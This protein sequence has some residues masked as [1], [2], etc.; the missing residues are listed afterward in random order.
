MKASIQDLLKGLKDRNLTVR[1]DA[2]V[3]LAIMR[4]EV[5]PPLLELLREGKAFFYDSDDC[6]ATEIAY[7]VGQ[8]L[9]PQIAIPALIELLKTTTND[10][11][12]KETACA[13]RMVGPLAKDAVFALNEALTNKNPNTRRD[14]ALALGAIGQPDKGAI[15][16]LAGILQDEK[17]D[18]QVRAAATR[19]LGMLGPSAS[20]AIRALATR[21]LNDFCQSGSEIV[22][23][24]AI[25]AHAVMQQNPTAA[26]SILLASLHESGDAEIRQQSA[27]AIKML[28]NNVLAAP[29]LAKA[30]SELTQALEDPHPIVRSEIALGLAALGAAATK[31]DKA[32]A[33]VLSNDPDVHVRSAAAEALR[34]IAPSADVVLE[35][36]TGALDVDH[37]KDAQVREL[38]VLALHR[39][40]EQARPAIGKLLLCLED[41]NP[42]VC[43][44]AA[45]A[46]R[47]IAPYQEA[48]VKGLAQ[49]LSSEFPEVRLIVATV[50]GDFASSA[51]LAAPGLVA[52]LNDGDQWVRDEASH[53]LSAVGEAAV[54]RLLDVMAKATSDADRQR[55]ARVIKDIDEEAIPGLLKRLEDKDVN[56]GQAVVEL[57]KSMSKHA[58]T[59]RS[60]LF[61][62]LDD[63]APDK[64]HAKLRVLSILGGL[65]FD[66]ATS[67]SKLI[68]LLGN[69][70]LAEF[71][72][73][74]LLASSLH[75]IRPLIEALAAHNPILVGSAAGT[76]REIT[77]RVRPD[78][79][80]L[81]A[82]LKDAIPRLKELLVINARDPAP[83]REIK[84]MEAVSRNV[85]G[86]LK[87]LAR[88][89]P[90]A[91]DALAPGIGRLINALSDPADLSTVGDAAQALTENTKRADATNE[92]FVAALR[93]IVPRLKKLL[94]IY[95][96]DPIAGQAATQS[97]IRNVGGALKELAFF[98]PDAAL[99]RKTFD[100]NHE[101]TDTDIGN[102]DE[103]GDRGDCLQLS[104]LEEKLDKARVTFDSVV[105][106]LAEERRRQARRLQN[107]LNKYLLLW[108]KHQQQLDEIGD[109]RPAKEVFQAKHELA[110]RVSKR[111]GSVHFAIRYKDQ[112]NDLMSNSSKGNR[113]GWFLLRPKGISTPSVTKA[114]L[115]DLLNITSPPGGTP[116][117]ELVEAPA[118]RESL[119]EWRERIRT[120]FA[121][122]R[123][124]SLDR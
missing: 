29:Q 106:M 93:P 6:P 102:R 18:A 10:L 74:L 1:R 118:R 30:L 24:Q 96:R 119:V 73:S 45:L 35:A 28:A 97:A 80:E 37:E 34:F 68:R 122:T 39:L 105:E 49:A 56:V 120:G 90:D 75:V 11:V 77:R 100:S 110:E 50:L 91:A 59:L 41:S 111:L 85:R 115:A 107:A 55:A 23:I 4:Q 117:F 88:F 15:Q 84:E 62:I 98:Y 52:L 108:A 32:L 78:E 12:V 44:R 61:D 72:Q 7:A 31:A 101:F 76:L 43:I 70:Y 89:F 20:K 16:R 114:N 113:R 51:E 60:C 104:S 53:A 116:G 58:E 13:L 36:L 82:A 5:L 86:A 71:V 22:R 48:S 65:G 47:A 14:A 19:A 9:Y 69:S 79:N 42:A 57:L 81:L 3:T 87:E 95:S 92:D 83:V 21:V 121:H 8:T 54:P 25:A 94:V 2:A 99:T 123:E 109:G 27:L 38:A 26:I 40:G 66:S 63:P 33:P 67:V 17:E 46:L 124:P 64:N 112:P 103:A